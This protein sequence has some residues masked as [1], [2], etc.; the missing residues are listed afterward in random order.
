MLRSYK[1]EARTDD[2]YFAYW[3]TGSDLYALSRSFDD[4]MRELRQRARFV[5]ALMPEIPMVEP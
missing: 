5:V 2:A 1:I 4:L 3:P